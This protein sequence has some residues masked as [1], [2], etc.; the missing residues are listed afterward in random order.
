MLEVLVNAICAFILA[1]SGFYIIKKITKSNEKIDKRKIIILMINAFSIAII[2]TAEYNS[3]S[4]L[5][6]F[7]INTLTYKV[8]FH[9][10][11]EK[12][13]IATGL[14][15]LIVVSADVIFSVTQ[16][17]LVPLAKTYSDYV[18][19]FI[20]NMI[21]VILSL[22][23][24]SIKP[25]ESRMNKFFIT[26][27]KK[28][29][30]INVIFILFIM[31][32]ISFFVYNV[33]INYQ[34][35]SKFLSDIIVIGSAISIGIIFISN[36]ETY[37]KL[38]DEYDVLLSSVQNLE[39]WIEN[40]QFIRHEYKNQLAV[41]YELSG[42]KDVKN[43]IQEIIDENLNI[44][45]EVITNLT[46]LPKGGLK[47]LIYY[48]TIVA[49]NNKINIT[50]NTSI[51]TKGILS[52]LNKAQITTLSKLIGVYLDNAIDAAKKSRKKIILLEIYELKNRVNIVISNTF[53]KSSLVENRYDKGITTKGEGHGQGLYFARKILNKNNW[54]EEK[55]EIIDNYYIETITIKNTSKK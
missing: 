43:K 21:I 14:L 15:S 37:D 49:K 27:S 50:I 4:S 52:K 25:I 51:N 5:I 7:V 41:L 46:N 48:K 44:N 3:I 42:E 19:Y 2:R 35:N 32:I 20:S 17:I 34:F 39:E 33:I 54:I 31:I 30:K 53:N 9:E 11:I 36:K 1:L 55:Q 23:I 12:A 22:I 40:E 26:L 6:S 10:T 38:S 47:G 24:I 8:L 18:T 45:S 28:D 16:L 13:A 29:L